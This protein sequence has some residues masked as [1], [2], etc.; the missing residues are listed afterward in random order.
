M[1]AMTLAAHG[2]RDALVLRS[3]LEAPRPGQGQVRV[4]VKATGVNHV[5]GVLRRGYPGL[6]LSLPHILGGDVAGVIDEV[7]EGVDRARIGERVVV[8]PVSS[9][10]TCLPCRRGNALTCMGWQFLGMQRAGGYAEFCV[11]DH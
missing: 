11:V 2:G 9:C 6:Q 8:Y 7:G 1:K 4:S 5:D 3:D 10:G